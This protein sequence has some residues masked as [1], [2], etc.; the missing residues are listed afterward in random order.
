MVIVARID[1]ELNQLN[2]KTSSLNSELK[3]NIYMS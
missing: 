3:K 2:V 1:F